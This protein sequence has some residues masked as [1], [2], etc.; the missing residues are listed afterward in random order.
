MAYVTADYK[1]VDAFG[2]V[3]NA[4]VTGPGEWLDGVVPASES[5]AVS[6][7]ST[8]DQTLASLLSLSETA[9]AS[10]TS[11]VNGL[12]NYT[13]DNDLTAI[14][15]TAPE[16]SDISLSTLDNYPN[17]TISN[18][19]SAS[20]AVSRAPSAF[21]D[22]AAPNVSVAEPTIPLPSTPAAPNLNNVGLTQPL[23]PAE[24]VFSTD[25]T[26]PTLDL[27]SLSVTIPDSPDLDT[28]ELVFPDIIDLQP[29][30]FTIDTSKIDEAVALLEGINIPTETIPEYNQL[31]TGLYEV[32]GSMLN[33]SF[34]IVDYVMYDAPES[35]V[36]KL[37]NRIG[38]IVPDSVDAYEEWLA[39][40]LMAHHDRRILV[41]NAREKDT[42]ALAAYQL[43]TDAELLLYDIAV[44][45][46]DA[47][48]KYLLA[49]AEARAYQ[50]KAIALAYNAKITAIDGQIVAYN[51]AVTELKAQAQMALAQSSVVSLV[52]DSNKLLAREFA[53]TEGAKDSTA[54]V[55]AARVQAEAAKLSAYRSELE[56]YAAEVT[57]AEARGLTYAAEVEEYL[58]QIQAFRNEY[59]LYSVKADAVVQDNRKAIA[60]IRA[61]S[62]KTSAYAAQARALASQVSVEGIKKLR[63][64]LDAS[65]QY[66]T[67]AN[68]NAKVEADITKKLA[69]ITEDL[70]NYSGG[71]AIA[72]VTSDAYTKEN[73]LK[74]EYIKLALDSSARAAEASQRANESL[75]RAYASAYEA[76]GRAGASLAAGQLSGFRASAS[77]SAS[78][79]FSGTES[80]GTTYT[81]TGTNDYQETDLYN[82]N[83]SL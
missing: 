55:Y 10:A 83:I 44:K 67:I 6:H 74:G 49:Q 81:S 70:T 33:Q 47:R 42:V 66:K 7:A 12:F 35:R 3:G 71:M 61:D 78:G 26:T 5:I 63:Q 72:S 31:F 30:D 1:T 28:I 75:V 32:V 36:K 17:V 73:Q 15:Y 56:A 8:V 62:T 45:T 79:S 38:E 80:Y 39:D 16:W 18:A 20:S 64:Y 77:L 48:F 50:A 34:G 59:E 13:F 52:G 24:Y 4:S 43:G 41:S 46:R 37:I 27:G 22:V 9:S 69:S 25:R 57:T 51:A 68:K 11:V 19:P 60:E 53:V 21:N 65:G 14:S 2:N 76:A 40:D 23:S 58:A 29:L 54:K 82:Q